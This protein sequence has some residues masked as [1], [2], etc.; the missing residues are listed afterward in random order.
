MGAG[1][2]KIESELSRIFPQAALNK[3]IFI[4]TQSIIG[5]SDKEFD[6]VAALSID[7]SLNRLDFRAAEKTYQILSGLA[8]LTQKTMIVES[9]LAGHHI[10]SALLKNEPQR[11]YDLE[12]EQRK[13]LEF[14]PFAH[15]VLVKL[16]GK[17][18]D[19]VKVAAEFLFK[20]LDEEAKGK[21]IKIISL[22]PAQPSKLRGNFCWQ[23]L[24]RG[25]SAQKISRFLKLNLKKFPH[26]GIIVTVDVDPL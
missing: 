26:S 14:V 11:F 22:N 3:D 13:S 21:G 24:V 16:R 1:V 4:S 23:I 19:K 7:N 5:S 25:G 18:E 2:E 9:G 20:R 12:L 15:F 17:Q 10:F 6:L 8:S